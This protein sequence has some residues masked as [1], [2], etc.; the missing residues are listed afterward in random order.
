MLCCLLRCLMNIYIRAD[1]YVC[2]LPHVLLKRNVINLSE[3]HSL[4][5]AR[6]DFI[7]LS[8]A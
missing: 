5:C 7:R 2:D 1:K 6:N 8:I 4:S 3:Y